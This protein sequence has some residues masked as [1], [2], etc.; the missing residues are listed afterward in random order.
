MSYTLWHYPNCST[1]KKAIK[2][3]KANDVDFTAIDLVKTPPSL[4]AIADLHSRSGLPVKRFF[5]T[6]GQSY[7]GGGFKEK[8][9]T[10][11]EAD[12]HAALAADGK[13]IKRPILE[14]G[15]K[16]LVGFK[17]AEYSEAIG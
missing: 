11:S 6:S 7:R 12:C 13:L 4:E 16:V 15:E 9:P 3:L 14:L 1:C 5:N 8:L 2:W 10:M 17:E